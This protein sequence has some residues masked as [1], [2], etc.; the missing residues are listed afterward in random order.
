MIIFDWN[1]RCTC[2]EMVS[3]CTKEFSA[4]GNGRGSLTE[5]YVRVRLQ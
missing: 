5:R 3:G 2:G 4:R 1:G